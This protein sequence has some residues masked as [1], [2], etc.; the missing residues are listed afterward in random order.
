MFCFFPLC[1]LSSSEG[2]NKKWR[3]QT[4]VCAAVGQSIRRWWIVQELQGTHENCRLELGLPAKPDLAT[5]LETASAPT[6]YI[7]CIQGMADPF[8]GWGDKSLLSSLVVCDALIQ[9]LLSQ[10][11]FL[12]TRKRERCW[13][14]F[15]LLLFGFAI[16]QSARVSELELVRWD[17]E[18][19]TQISWSQ[20][21]VD[22]EESSRWCGSSYEILLRCGTPCYK[23]LGMPKVYMDLKS[24][25]V[26]SQKKNPEVY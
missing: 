6:V 9:C 5:C 17:R 1:Y 8:Q 14:S 15:F 22:A 23:V 18:I 3:K 26:K 25:C 4:G 16:P 19:T 12:S 10:Q 13:M 2:L 11:Q 21:I 7:F 20:Q 24:S